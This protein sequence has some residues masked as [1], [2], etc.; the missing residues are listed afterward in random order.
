[1][2]IRELDFMD[3]RSYGF[4]FSG[5]I[6]KCRLGDYLKAAHLADVGMEYLETAPGEISIYTPADVDLEK[7]YKILD[8][9]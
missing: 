5:K 8:G 9:D 7:F 2:A 3:A 6:K 4:T 1:M